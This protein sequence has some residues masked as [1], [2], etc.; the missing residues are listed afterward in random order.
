MINTGG[1]HYCI[2]LVNGHNNIMSCCM[3]LY[4]RC[5]L[6]FGINHVVWLKYVPAQRYLKRTRWLKGTDDR[7]R[8]RMTEWNVCSANPIPPQCDNI[9][10]TIR[11]GPSR[12]TLHA[13][14]KPAAVGVA[15]VAGFSRAWVKVCCCN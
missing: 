15:V 14:P 10:I 5:M 11:Q 3:A 4:I 7:T 13:L 6:G 12:V 1:W 2:I 9:D 8:K